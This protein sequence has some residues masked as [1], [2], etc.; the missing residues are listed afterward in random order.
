MMKCQEFKNA[1]KEDFMS[2]KTCMDGVVMNFA[3]MYSMYNKK[4]IQQL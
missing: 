1:K 4:Y 2:T 3:I